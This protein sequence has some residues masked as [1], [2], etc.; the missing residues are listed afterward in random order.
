[1]S[2]CKKISPEL[3]K[4]LA[5]EMEKECEG[6]ENEPADPEF[7]ERMMKIVTEM[8]NNRKRVNNY[9]NSCGIARVSSKIR[10]FFNN[11]SE[12]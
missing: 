3:M 10:K 9:K 2:K 12:R 5:E 6:W 7:V 11:R 4:K 8:E 1:M